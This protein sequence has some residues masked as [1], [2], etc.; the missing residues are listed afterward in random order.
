MKKGVKGRSAR[1]SAE[2]MKS[3]EL[4]VGGSVDMRETGGNGITEP[5]GLFKFHIDD[6]VAGITPGNRYEEISFGNPVGRELL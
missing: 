4:A 2:S 6:L 5:V 1:R 3:A